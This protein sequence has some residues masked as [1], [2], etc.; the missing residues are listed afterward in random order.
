MCECVNGGVRLV[1]A[2]CYCVG[3]PSC[4][5]NEATTEPC[6][7]SKPQPKTHTYPHIRVWVAWHFVGP[8]RACQ[9]TSLLPS[10][11][12]TLFGG[13]IGL[14]IVPFIGFSWGNHD[15]STCIYA[16]IFAVRPLAL[17]GKN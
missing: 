7:Y 5:G 13:L 9:P 12:L 2:P 6:G 16:R 17:L 4:H 15:Q 10:I 14:N 11:K 1:H 8:L 3:H